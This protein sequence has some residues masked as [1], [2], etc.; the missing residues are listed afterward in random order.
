[1]AQ[2]PQK[3]RGHKSSSRTTATSKQTARSATMTARLWILDRFVR[4]TSETK[5]LVLRKVNKYVVWGEP[6]DDGPLADKLLNI[7]WYA[8]NVNLPALRTQIE[9]EI[10]KHPRVYKTKG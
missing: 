3:A 7:Y 4:G 8:T 1:M 5:Q 2:A 10:E 6:K 9:N